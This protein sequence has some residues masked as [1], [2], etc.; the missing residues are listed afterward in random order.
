MKVISLKYG[1]LPFPPPN[2]TLW[3][4]L[5][6]RVNELLQF[7]WIGHTAS[8]SFGWVLEHQSF[9][10][11]TTGWGHQQCRGRCSCQTFEAQRAVLNLVTAKLSSGVHHPQW[12]QARWRSGVLWSISPEF[13][14]ILVD[15]SSLELCF[16]RNILLS[17]EGSKGWLVRAGRLR[18]MHLDWQFVGVPMLPVWMWCSRISTRWRVKGLA[19][20][21]GVWLWAIGSSLKW[22]TYTR[23]WH[24]AW[25]L[26]YLQILHNVSLHSCLVPLTGQSPCSRVT[27]NWHVPCSR[28]TCLS[29]PSPYSMNTDRFICQVTRGFLNHL[30]ECTL[31]KW[32]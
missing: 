6:W 27:T 7:V 28:N 1:V 26:R 31:C 29:L 14:G 23:K 20:L 15:K 9:A 32:A 25:A 16:S 17:K 2:L 30:S 24:L 3:P 11:V 10:W 21:L 19:C 18:W 4:G 8:C 22:W 5:I 12:G 13:S